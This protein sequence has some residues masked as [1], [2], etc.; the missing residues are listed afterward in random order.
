[1]D[2]FCD[3]RSNHDYMEDIK[4]GD[5]V[6]GVFNLFVT[7]RNE[8]NKKITRKDL[9][10]GTQVP[11]KPKNPS[12]E[13][14]YANAEGKQSWWKISIHSRHANNRFEAWVYKE[15]EIVS[16]VFRL[17]R[18]LIAHDLKTGKAVKDLSDLLEG[19][20]LVED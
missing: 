6:P 17:D 20:P 7:D 15:D 8:K 9:F 1:V 18:V 13:I 3:Y 14:L 5:F 12:Y 11:K 10:K 16:L 4:S 2:D 19:V